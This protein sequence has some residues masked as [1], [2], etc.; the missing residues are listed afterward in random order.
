MKSYIPKSFELGG[1]EWKVKHGSHNS[2]GNFGH[3][4][5]MKSEVIVKSKY[6]GK[7]FCK[8]Q[9]EQTFYHELSH[10]ILI[11][12]N[13]HELNENEKFVDVLGQFIYQF[14]KSAKWK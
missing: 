14:M 10:T 2:E 13:E 7:E 8:Q 11:T 3:T 4:D 12:M 9:Q 5:I 1:I 6:N